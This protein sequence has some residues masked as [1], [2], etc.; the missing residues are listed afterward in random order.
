MRILLV[1][2]LQCFFCVCVAQES[3][4]TQ[5]DSAV[6]TQVNDL[7]EGAWKSRFGFFLSM[8]PFPLL[9]GGLG[10]GVEFLATP[11][12][13][14]WAVHEK[15]RS[16]NR[17]FFDF[18]FGDETKISSQHQMLGIRFYNPLSTNWLKG[19]YVQSGHKW[20][21]VDTTV[22]P[23]LF[24]GSQ[25]SRTDKYKGVYGGL[26][27][28][29]VSAR[30]KPYRVMIDVAINY[31]PGKVYDIQYDANGTQLFGSNVNGNAMLSVKEKHYIYPD[32]RFGIAF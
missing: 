20:A 22:Y 8:A 21:D 10:L 1:F 13:S 5:S 9:G 14:L 6:Q 32:V 28:R 12:I 30:R 3:S 18:S 4:T 17:G 23:G 15:E 16:S 24:N 29:L 25:V 26:G 11:Y 2:M 27:Y 7:A 31:E 19:F